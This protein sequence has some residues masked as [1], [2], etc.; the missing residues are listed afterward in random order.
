MVLALMLVNISSNLLFIG[1]GTDQESLMSIREK[2]SVNFTSRKEPKKTFR[3]GPHGSSSD[4]PWL[5]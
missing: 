2:N 4:E 5:Q 3:I 1:N